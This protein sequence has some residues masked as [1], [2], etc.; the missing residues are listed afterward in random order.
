MICTSAE[1][2]IALDTRIL[3]YADGVNGRAR[4]ERALDLLRAHAVDDLLIPE[5]ALGE[6]FVVLTRKARREAAQ[7]RS[8]VL[9]W[10]DR[11]AL[12]GTTP[13]VIH[14]AMELAASHR[15]AFWDSVILAGA[16]QVGCRLLLSEDMQDG[17]TWRSV[18][19][20]N[21]FNGTPLGAGV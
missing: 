18:T 16:A 11:F 17:F 20:C 12:I 15:L 19:V 4:E 1:V 8:A 21:P 2:R 13:A 7:A 3:A 14:E 5:Q 9:G 6:R 10:S